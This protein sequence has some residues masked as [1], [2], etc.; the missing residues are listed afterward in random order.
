[1]KKFIVRTSTNYDLE[2][3]ADSKEDAIEK[4]SHVPSN[5]WGETLDPLEAEEVEES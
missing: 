4:A 3:E 2:I 5:L 1:M